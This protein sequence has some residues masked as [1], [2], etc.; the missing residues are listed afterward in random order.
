MGTLPLDHPLRLSAGPHNLVIEATGF[1][2]DSRF[3]D[4]PARA[5]VREHTALAPVPVLPQP[6]R[7]AAADPE[8]APAVQSSGATVVTER[9]GTEPAP[10]EASAPIY[11]RWWFWTAIGVV[12]VAAGG[13]AYLLLSRNDKCN[14]AGGPCVTW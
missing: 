4:V 2:S 6:P 10:D 9:S 3:V 12:A 13:T 8:P 1:V 7:L 5:A 11:K 14:S